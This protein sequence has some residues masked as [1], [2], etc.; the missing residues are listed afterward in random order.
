MIKDIFVDLHGYHP[1]DIDISKIV[2]AAWECGGDTLTIIHGHGHNR[3]ISVGFV[4]TN[5]GYFGLFI[6]SELRNDKS[7][8]KWIYYTTLDCSRDGSTTVRIKPNKSP[9]RSKFEP[10]LPP[11]SYER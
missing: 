7:L 8:R 5:T 6:R 10:D 1:N 2:Y 11:F 9:S 3:G 4:N